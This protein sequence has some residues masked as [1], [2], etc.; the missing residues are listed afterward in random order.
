MVVA[1]VGVDVGG[2]LGVVVGGEAGDGG[3]DGAGDGLA[4]WG[5]GVEEGIEAWVG[6]ADGVEHAGVACGE[7]APG[8][9]SFAWLGGDGLGDESADAAEVD[10]IA[11]LVEDAAGSGG[12]DDGGSEVDAGEVGVQVVH[13]WRVRGGKW[14]NGQMGLLVCGVAIVG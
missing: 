14:S 13:W 10:D 8:L 2:A 6:Q 5:V 11:H 12:E 9:V 1:D 7:D 4:A 3:E